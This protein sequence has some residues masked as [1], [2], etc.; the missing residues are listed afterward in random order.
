M[1][2]IRGLTVSSFL[3]G[4]VLSGC[5]QSPEKNKEIVVM[6]NGNRKV[7]GTLDK[8]TVYSYTL[9]NGKGLK[10][11]ISNYGGTLLELW[12]PDRSGKTGDVILGFDSL[13]GYLQKGNP[14]F[15]ALVGRYA[16]RI[17]NARFSIDGKLY[18]LAANNNGNTL[19][20]GIK[21]FDKVIWTVDQVNDSSLALSYTSPDGEEGF[22][23]TMTVKVVYTVTGD[24]GLKIDYT[25]VSDKKTPVNLTNH[26]YFNLSAGNDSTVLQQE[27]TLHASHYTP[28]NDSLIPTGKIASVKNTPMDF[29]K[30]KKVGRDIA[31]VKGGYDLNFVIDKPDSGIALAAS[32]YDEGSGRHM[33]VWTTQPGVQF[34]TGNFL[35]GSLTGRDGKKI[36]QHGALCLETQHYPDSPNEP[37]FPNVILGPGQTF[38]ETTVYKFSVK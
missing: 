3:L 36:V 10:A 1:G 12:T 11:V 8:D 16:N 34:Y 31:D 38:H 4:A 2:T 24:N 7:F 23:G 21:G 33:Q 25:A 15:G 9:Q 22:P 14:Y 13:A 30:P 29:L 26:A 37:S 17:G 28:V 20:G 5:N 6:E 35:D 32:V 18:T 27:L 19:H